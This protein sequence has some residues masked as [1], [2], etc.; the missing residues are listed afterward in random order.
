MIAENTRAERRRN[1]IRQSEHTMSGL[2]IPVMD[3]AA[4]FGG[5]SPARDRTDAAITEAASAFGFF[6]ASALPGDVP[7][8]RESRA[9]RPAASEL[10]P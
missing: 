4:L 5:P 7:I 8:D 1:I 10:R 2:S 9:E 6:A 3:V